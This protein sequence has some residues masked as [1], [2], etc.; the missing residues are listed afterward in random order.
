MSDA[1]HHIAGYKVSDDVYTR[2]KLYIQY[3]AKKRIKDDVIEYMRMKGN[4][5]DENLLNLDEP[6]ERK[7]YI[8]GYSIPDVA[9]R[10]Y[11]LYLQH[12]AK[13]TTKDDI[14]EYIHTK[15]KLVE[16]NL[17]NLVGSSRRTKARKTRTGA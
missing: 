11:K 2:Y 12:I 16:E 15:A 4:L 6:S 1:T 7:Y 13:K 9:F 3:I 8:G 17:L 10:K 14:I 5:V